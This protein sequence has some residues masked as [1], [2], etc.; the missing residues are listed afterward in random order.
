MKI[1]EYLK[2]ENPIARWIVYV[3][4]G[5]FVFWLGSLLW[6][7]WRHL[8]YRGQINRCTD[9]GGLR[10]QDLVVKDGKTGSALTL[11]GSGERVFRAFQIEKGLQKGGPVAGHLC[12]IFEA[13]WNESQLDARGL[14]KNTTDEL[15]RINTLHRSLLSIFIILGLLGTL[16][17]LADTMASLNTLLRGTAQLN[18][19]TLSQGLQRLLGTLKGAFAPSIWGVSLTVLGV[20]I[21][22]FYLRIVALPLGGLL[23]RITLTV[24][25]PQLVPTASQ[26]LLEKLQLSERQMQRSFE[27]AQEVAKFAEGIQHKTGAFGETLDLTT[28]SLRQM[29]KTADGLETFSRNFVNAVSILTSF[30]E[31]LR[32][33]YQQMVGES[34]SFQEN[35]QRNIAGAEGFQQRIQEQ[36]NGQHEQLVQVLNALQSYEAAYVTNR[37][38]ID[39]K[40]GAVL[41]QAERAFQSLGERNEEIGQALDGA[42][43]KPL[44]EDLSLGLG[45][46]ES[47]LQERLVEV[48]DTLLVQLGSLGDR[49]RQLDAPLKN[50]ADKFSD[51]FSNF[52]EY[53]NEWR[54]TL[55][56]EFASQNE[57]NQQQLKRLD[58]LSEEI[59]ALL[60]QLTISSNNFSESSSSFTTQG[61]ELS[62]HTNELSQNIAALG[63]GVDALSEQVSK[64][65]IGGGDRLAELLAEQTDISQE[66]TRR[67]GGSRSRS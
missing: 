8:R 10:A 19:D 23:E 45:A 42:L 2:P 29:G 55:Q 64:Q 20:L 39:E 31:D 22:A 62:Q 40:L 21:F 57:T 35:V 6:S 14:I 59:P 52:N 56:R 27:A 38:K 36:L 5:L 47:Q 13:G 12:A 15:F 50:A 66:L 26:K 9:V 63:R 44:R 32:A 16:F 49:L 7:L 11:P 18:N 53:T 46:L 3:L 33:L 61:Q 34:R 65:R 48:K 4:V 41:I 25:I 60:Q 67:L 37:E 30:Q 54:T 24:W 58:L 43:G 17:G 28:K 51:T 1:L